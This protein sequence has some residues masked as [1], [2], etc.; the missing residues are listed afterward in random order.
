MIIS[1][2]KGDRQMKRQTLL[3]TGALGIVGGA[4]IYLFGG[5]MAVSVVCGIVLFLLLWCINR[6][7]KAATVLMKSSES[8]GAESLLSEGKKQ[9]CV[10]DDCIAAIQDEAVHAEA[11]SV[12]DKME[13]IWNTLEEE[14]QRTGP[15][16]DFFSYYLPVFRSILA[17]YQKLE[18]NGVE[19]ESKEMVGKALSDIGE[20][21][22]RLHKS[23]FEGDILDLSADIKVM[24][25]SL[26]SAGLMG[27]D[28]RS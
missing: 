4:I 18:E 21:M 9:L 2:L 17:R 27:S 14:P 16:A 7:Q 5:N 11:I 28:W 15:A 26:Q 6:P 12:R 3:V 13:K 22:E 24:N 10:I 25:Q 8:T 20:A 1:S 23:L 19:A